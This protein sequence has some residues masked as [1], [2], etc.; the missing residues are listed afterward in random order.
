MSMVILL[1][2][3]SGSGK[4]LIGQMLASELGFEFHD[5][6]DFHSAQNVQ[7]MRSGVPLTDEDRAPWLASLAALI[8]DAVDSGDNI[9]L[10]CSALTARSRAVLRTH[11]PQ[12]RLVHLKGDREL[13]RGRMERR[14][15]HY[16]PPSLLDDQFGILEEDP[17]AVVIDI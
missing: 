11:L 2:G 13:V 9:V 5:A 8:G 17:V 4:T 16:M 14:T 7:K 6:D 1:M 15:D 12:V 3:V 10:A